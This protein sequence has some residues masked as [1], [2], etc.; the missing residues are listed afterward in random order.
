MGYLYDSNPTEEGKKE[1][2]RQGRK[3]RSKHEGKAGERERAREKARTEVSSQCRKPASVLNPCW[4]PALL[5]RSPFDFARALET[6]TRF[7]H[8]S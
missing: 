4:T 7:F 5:T 6:G 1:A 3:T 2:R 8:K